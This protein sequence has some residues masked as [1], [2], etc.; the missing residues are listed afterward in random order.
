MEYIY[1]VLGASYALWIF[2]MAVMNLDKCKRNKTLTKSA[3]VLALP[4]LVIGFLLD[5]LVQ[6]TIGTVMFLDIPREITLSA[7]LSRYWNDDPNDN[8]W[9]K[10]LAGWMKV[11]ILDPFDPDGIHIK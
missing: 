8:N 2:Y 10:K 1:Y 5:V 7:R 3:L 6:M 9:R 4:V 11:N